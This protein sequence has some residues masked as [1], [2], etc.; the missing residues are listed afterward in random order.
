V[1]DA[2][3]FLSNADPSAIEEL[4]QQYRKDP[5]SVDPSWNLFFQGFEFSKAD[6]TSGDAV[7]ENMHKEFRVLQLIDGYRSRGHLFTKTNPVRE[8]RKYAPTLDIENFGLEAVDLGTVFQAGEQ[9]GI[10]PATLQ[11]I[12]DHLTETYCQSIGIEFMYIRHPERVNWIPQA[13]RGQKSPAVQHRR[14]QAHPAQGE[15]GDDL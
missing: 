13:H 11:E 10:G 3:S 15:P 5:D 1:K 12:I 2:L 7:P 6:Y 4:Y 9:V 14:A 8:R